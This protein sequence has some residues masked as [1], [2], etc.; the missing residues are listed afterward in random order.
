[1]NR[2]ELR[3][4]GFNDSLDGDGKKIMVQT[5]VLGRGGPKIRTTVLARGVVQTS[6]DQPCDA[7]MNVEEVREAALLQHQRILAEAR[8]KS[9]LERLDQRES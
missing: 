6:E 3:K 8:V 9:D 2:D 1:M 4:I 7:R 5:E